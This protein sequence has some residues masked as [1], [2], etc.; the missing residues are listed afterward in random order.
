MLCQ[1][2]HTYFH[3]HNLTTNQKGNCTKHKNCYCSTNNYYWTCNVFTYMHS[4]YWNELLGLKQE[5]FPLLLISGVSVPQGGHLQLYHLKNG[6][7]FQH[8][9]DL[10]I[11]LLSCLVTTTK[12]ERIVNAVHFNSQGEWFHHYYH[13]KLKTTLDFS[14]TCYT[15]AV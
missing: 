14:E 10:N 11:H 4:R 13:A 3:K 9:S 7:H 15:Q 8:S 2:C 5:F 6:G 1:T 12:K